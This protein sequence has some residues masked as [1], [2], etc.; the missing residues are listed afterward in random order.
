MLALGHDVS[1][2]E[3]GA[4]LAYISEPTSLFKAYAM[5]SGIS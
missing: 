5:D 2:G 4:K 3:L 1:Q